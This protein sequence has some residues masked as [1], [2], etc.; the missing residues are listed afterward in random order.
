VSSQIGNDL[1]NIIKIKINKNT[2]YLEYKKP[3][4]KLINTKKNKKNQIKLG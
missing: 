2:P 4:I 1:N 3:N